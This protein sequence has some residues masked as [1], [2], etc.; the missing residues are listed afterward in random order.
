[1]KHRI[2]RYLPYV[3]RQTLSVIYILVIVAAMAMAG[4]A[5]VAFGGAGG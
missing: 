2:L 4:G 3:N 5:P 1:M